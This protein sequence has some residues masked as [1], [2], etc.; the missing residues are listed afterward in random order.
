MSGHRIGMPNRYFD[1]RL[2]PAV[3]KAMSAS[4]DVLREAGA[5]ILSV[6][7]PHRSRWRRACVPLM[8]KAESAANHRP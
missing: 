8:M 5:V 4:L 3:E 7:F 6:R 2:D 1:E